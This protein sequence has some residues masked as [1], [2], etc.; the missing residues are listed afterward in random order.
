MPMRFYV[1]AFGA[2]MTLVFLVVHQVVQRMLEPTHTLRTEVERG[3][4]ARALLQVG[5]VLGVFLVSASTVAN[6]VEGNDLARDALWAAAFGGMALALL[7]ITGRMGVRMLLKHELPAEIERGNV[8]AGVAAA[9][10]YIATGIITS[11]AIAGND[12]PSLGL[13]FAFFCIAQITLHVAIA[14]FRLLTSYDDAQEIKGENLAVGLSYAGLTIAVALVIGRAV[15]GS[16]TG[17]VSS[18]RS[19][20]VALQYLIAL[21]I[22]RQLVVQTIILRASFTLRGGAL[23]VGVGEKRNVAMGALEA[24]TYVAAALLAAKL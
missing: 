7:A 5:H 3:N 22:V 15:E 24:V 10:H 4:V 12:L 23:D 17:W 21:Y 1:P 2:V 11:K 20:A 19:Y 13:S 8:A 18:L 6:C 9:G 14:L 16:F